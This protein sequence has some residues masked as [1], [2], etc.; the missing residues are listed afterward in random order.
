M[1]KLEK[2]SSYKKSGVEWLGEIPA[3]WELTRLGTKFKERKEK[4]SD[5]DYEPLSV[6]R[7]GIVP[8]FGMS[9]IN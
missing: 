8:Q 5:K 1:S 3:G 7:N 9:P 2:Y 6:T 4:V